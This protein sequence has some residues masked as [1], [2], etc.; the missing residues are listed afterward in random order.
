MRT[1]YII[2]APAGTTELVSTVA[3]NANNPKRFREANN[4]GADASVREATAAEIETY[5]SRLALRLAAVTPLPR[6]AKP[7]SASATRR[8]S[9]KVTPHEQRLLDKQAAE[10]DVTPN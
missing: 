5:K 1:L 8:T 10:S 3:F 2:S 7:S 4:L 6:I 9:L